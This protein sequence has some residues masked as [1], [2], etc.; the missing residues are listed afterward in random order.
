MG[1]HLSEL[2]LR[3]G[4]VAVVMTRMIMPC[5]IVTAMVMP[6]VIVTARVMIL[7]LVVGMFVYRVTHRRSLLACVLPSEHPV[8]TIG[9]ST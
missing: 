7:V 8:A 6:C 5:M 9:S 2:A 1:V 4:T 3:L